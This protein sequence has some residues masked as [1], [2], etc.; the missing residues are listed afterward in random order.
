MK[1]YLSLIVL[2]LC[3]FV[4]VGCKKDKPGG[5]NVTG[6]V[7]LSYASW[8]DVNLDA[9]L[10]E[11]FERTHENVKIFRDTSIAGTGN[12]FTANLVAA[13]LA[14]TCPD[15][16]ITDSVPA[17][18]ENGLVRD[19]AEF[20]NNDDDAKLV[21]GNIANTA[22]YNG[23]RLAIP[24]FQY[25]KGMLVNKTLLEDI[26]AEIPGYDW[27]FTEFKEYCEE[28]SGTTR[29]NGHIVQGVNG[30]APNGGEATLGFEQVMPGQ[31]SDT[32]FYDAWNGESFD[33]TNELWI[34]YR[35]ETKYFFD[36]GLIEQ[37]SAEEKE[38]I[39]G[40]SDAYVF[41]EGDVMFGIEGSWNATTV[42]NNFYNNGIEVDF[43]PF[44]AGTKQQIPVILDYICV[45]SQTAHPA[46]AYEF[47]K[48]MSYGRDGMAARLSATEELH[49]TIN[50]FPVANYPE[51]WERINENI[52][53]TRYPGLKANIELLPNGIPDCDKWM[54][55]YGSFWGWVAENA[56]TQDF[57]SLPTDQLAAV[58]GTELN[59]QI[60]EAWEKLGLN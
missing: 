35:N 1:K 50:G 32:I 43:Y 52:D 21:Y 11:E 26:G 48:F 54:P 13:S 10:I 36:N 27:T 22:V 38:E 58:W 7:T 31:D 40:K 19:V 29:A 4:L 60:L 17:M 3:A 34:K 51:I 12:A 44:P 14:G 59:K 55:G 57:Y 42:V 6:K 33:Y 28:Y 5:G 9:L 25:I 24:S 23:K 45:S 53:E 41:E 2:L 46:L 16:F 30:F 18:I 8:G 56:E 20:W 47:A 15:V 49:Q 39:Y 37:M